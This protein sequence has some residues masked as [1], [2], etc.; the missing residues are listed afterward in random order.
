MPPPI[1]RAVLLAVKHERGHD[2]FIGPVDYDAWS[3]LGPSNAV[4]CIALLVFTFEGP[5]ALPWNGVFIVLPIQCKT[6]LE[7]AHFAL[8]VLTHEQ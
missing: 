5:D 4:Q 8:S 2:V 3:I 1:F 6:Q 7:D